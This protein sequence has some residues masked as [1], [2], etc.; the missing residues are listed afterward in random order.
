M[1]Q[2]KFCGGNMTVVRSNPELNV[3]LLKALL[4][5]TMPRQSHQIY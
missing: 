5:E 1:L 4:V 2:L 3:L